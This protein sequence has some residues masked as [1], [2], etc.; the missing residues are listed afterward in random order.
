MTAGLELRHD[1]LHHTNGSLGLFFSRTAVI[2]R[3]VRELCADLAE[4]NVGCGTGV[5][6]TPSAGVRCGYSSTQ[7]ICIQQGNSIVLVLYLYDQGIPISD[8]ASAIQIHFV[9]LGKRDN[10]I[11][12]EKTLPDIL[13]NDPV[14]GAL[15]LTLG[16]NETNNMDGEYDVGLEVTWGPDN[17]IE[18]T[19][20][21]GL[22]VVRD[23]I[24]FPN[25]P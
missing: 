7:R 9:A 20:K 14:V 11:G 21:R 17:T 8:L 15:K 3:E 24:P 6:G 1:A 13:V 5:G 23:I 10:V 2:M 16:S 19:F 12:A 22:N 18:W 4:C 25:A